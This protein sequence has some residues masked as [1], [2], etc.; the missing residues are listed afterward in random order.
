MTLQIDLSREEEER[1]DAMERVRGITPADMAKQL[2]AEILRGGL[3]DLER[4]RRRE[5]MR[6][7]VSES[8]HLRLYK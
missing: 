6:E 7:L 8:H 1:L 3:P 4:N 2:V 5:A